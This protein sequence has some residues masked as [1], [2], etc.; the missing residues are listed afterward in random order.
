MC[1]DKQLIT[2]LDILTSPFFSRRRRCDVPRGVL[3]D[4]TDS[5]AL[6]V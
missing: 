6:N 2:Y 1:K 4:R 5:F 3:L